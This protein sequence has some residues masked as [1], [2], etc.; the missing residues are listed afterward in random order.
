M[1]N[2]TPHERTET[3]AGQGSTGPGPA[4]DLMAGLTDTL[5]NNPMTCLLVGLGVGYVVARMFKR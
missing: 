5:R 3:A 1:T 2:P 4:G